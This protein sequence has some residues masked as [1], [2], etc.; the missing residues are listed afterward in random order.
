MSTTSGSIDHDH[1]YNISSQFVTCI[2]P[3]EL[4]RNASLKYY[5]QLDHGEAG[6]SLRSARQDASR[7][8]QSHDSTVTS[9]PLSD[10]GILTISSGITLHVLVLHEPRPA[11]VPRT[12]GQAWGLGQNVP[13]G[14]GLALHIVVNVCIK[15]TTLC[16]CFIRGH[17]SILFLISSCAVDRIYSGLCAHTNVRVAHQ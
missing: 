13:D 14:W 16:T 10:T 15:A 4:R 1:F 6:A 8:G 17:S 7:H 3:I 11:L 5:V 2:G 12:K 9:L